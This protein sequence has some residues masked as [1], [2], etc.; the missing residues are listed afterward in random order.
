MRQRRNVV[1]P[2]ESGQMTEALAP[3]AL[4]R[5]M[6]EVHP[7]ERPRE[8]L[9]D[10]GVDVL[11]EAELLAVLLGTGSQGENVLD[12]ARRVLETLGG[13]GGLVRADAALLRRTKGLGPAKAAQIAAA[14]E[15]GRRVPQLHPEARPL[16]D[17]P[18]AVFSLP[19][20]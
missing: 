9:L 3:I 11:S 15:L 8:R 14:I 13:V 4:N 2:V 19:P 17:R 1:K 6:R 10:H 7:D 5:T 18:E 20:P 12:L 16:M